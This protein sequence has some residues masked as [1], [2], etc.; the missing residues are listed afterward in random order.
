MTLTSSRPP[1]DQFPD[2]SP[3]PT[4]GVSSF[5]GVFGILGRRLP[6][7]SRRLPV[8]KS[9]S[10]AFQDAGAAKHYDEAVYRPGS[11]ASF[12]WQIESKRLVGIVERMAGD[13]LRYLDFACGIGRVIA[14]LEPLVGESTG[15]DIS[16]DM[17]TIARSH[18]RCS[19]LV[20]GEIK[21]GVLNGPYDMITVFRFF[22]NAEPALRKTTMA[23]LRAR[24]RGP[25]SRLIFNIH[26]NT[27]SLR[28]LAL[29]WREKRGELIGERINEMSYREVC[30]LVTECDLEIETWMGF[31]VVPEF[32]HRSRFGAVARIIDRTFACVP[33]MKFVSYDMLFVCRA[34]A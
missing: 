15:I 9:Y 19:E 34:R 24:L 12:I 14:L 16:S 32:L 23:A 29:M 18:L 13:D 6:V 3:A 25:D 27:N 2:A 10:K 30:E 31:G 1:P 20:V 33:M 11:Y 5:P 7:T 17:I 28:H 21:D 4:G 22:M 8:T 26:G